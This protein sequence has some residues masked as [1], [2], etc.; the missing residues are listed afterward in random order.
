MDNLINKK[1][2]AYKNINHSSPIQIIITCKYCK[3]NI[4]QCKCKKN[5]L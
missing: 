5:Q 4:K 1:P 3:K 2:D